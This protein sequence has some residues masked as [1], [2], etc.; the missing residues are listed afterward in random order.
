MNTLRGRST[1]FLLGS[2]FVVTLAWWGCSGGESTDQASSGNDGQSGETPASTD[3]GTDGG[4][5][6]AAAGGDPG[7][8]VYSLRC[9]TCH[10][11]TG[12]GDGIAGMALDP[13]PRDHTDAEYMATLSDEEIRTTILKG[14]GAM[15]P[16]EGILTDEELEFVI[17]YV[18]S[19]SQ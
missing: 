19:L 17:V 12:K 6:G 7:R 4:D 2:L 14:K 1:G 15:P 10:G 16:H 5:D 3:G 11:E 8:A 18:R 13:R 9:V